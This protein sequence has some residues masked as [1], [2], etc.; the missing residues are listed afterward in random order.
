MKKLLFI[1]VPGAGKGTQAQLLEKYGFKH[2]ST[3]DIIREAFKNKDPLLINYQEQYNKGILLSDELIFKLIEN[4]IK[5]S[6]SKGYVLDGAV[7][8]IPQAKF[9][10]NKDLVEEVFYF[11]LSKDMAIKRLISR[12]EISELKRSDDNIETFENRFKVYQKQTSPVIDY[13]KTKVKFHKIDASLSVEEI[14]QEVLKILKLV[15][16]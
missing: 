12:M 6:K 10:V 7:R 14:H 15:N 5:T 4:T 16:K 8:T 13:L 2:I 1:G 3:G 9:V 11:S